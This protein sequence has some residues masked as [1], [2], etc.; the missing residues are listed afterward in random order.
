MILLL[1]LKKN[2]DLYLVKCEFEVEIISYTD[3][4]KTEFFFNTSVVN[5]KNY[6]MYYIYRGTSDGRTF[7]HIHKTKIKTV[8]IMS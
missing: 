6:L 2:F 8:S 4:I 3:F 1:I 5:M 7:S